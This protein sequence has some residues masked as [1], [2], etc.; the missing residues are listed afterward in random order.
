MKR[1]ALFISILPSAATIPTSYIRYRLELCPT[2]PALKIDPV[3]SSITNKTN[4]MKS[5]LAPM[6]WW[7]VIALVYW[8]N[9]N[10]LLPENCSTWNF[11]FVKNGLQHLFSVSL[12]WNTTGHGSYPSKTNY[13]GR[14]GCLP[15]LGYTQTR[16]RHLLP[17]WPT[18]SF[19][20]IDEPTVSIFTLVKLWTEREAIGN[21]ICW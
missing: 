1:T 9:G 10:G 20:A 6:W 7:W 8:L 11:S 3:A 16:Q 15:A 14:C 21:A 18:S 5:K 12:T 4:V 2:W 13:K 19:V 17:S